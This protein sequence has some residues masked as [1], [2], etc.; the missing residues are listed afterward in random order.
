M[1]EINHFLT[2]S[3]TFDFTSEREWRKN[4]ELRTKDNESR[5]YCVELEKPNNVLLWWCRQWYGRIEC[6]EWLESIECN[7]EFHFHEL[8]VPRMA[9]ARKCW[10]EWLREFT[11]DGSA[12]E[13]RTNCTHRWML[14]CCWHT[15]RDG[16]NNNN[17]GIVNDTIWSLCLAL[18]TAN[19]ERLTECR[20]QYTHMR[21]RG[22]PFVFAFHLFCPIWNAFIAILFGFFSALRLS[23]IISLCSGFAFILRAHQI[24]SSICLRTIFFACVLWWRCL[25]LPF[26][27]LSLC[28]RGTRS[29]PSA[30]PSIMRL[31]YYLFSFWCTEYPGRIQ[32]GKQ[33]VASSRGVHGAHCT[34]LW[35]RCIFHYA[36]FWSIFLLFFEIE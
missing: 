34:P 30:A 36:I 11:C 35:L 28:V 23:H 1:M 20:A 24:M 2:Y 17:N 31:F 4:N 10:S 15:W 8:I 27:R 22:S 26:S 9:R 19:A 3:L 5:N 14:D 7:R 18:Q 32:K 6:T 16:I 13:R 21:K 25:C 33:R 12:R 29:Q